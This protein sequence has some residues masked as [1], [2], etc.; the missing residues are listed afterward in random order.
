MRIEGS[1][2][3]SAIDVNGENKVAWTM[4]VTH[5]MADGKLFDR[6]PVYQVRVDFRPSIQTKEGL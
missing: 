3:G 6:L 1:R 2:R 4:I 5:E